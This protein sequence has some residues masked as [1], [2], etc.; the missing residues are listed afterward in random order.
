M[1]PALIVI[2]VQKAFFNEDAATRQSLD[3]AVEYI[4]A[5]ICL[6]R[7]LHLPVV[8]VQHRE[9]EDGLIPGSEG[10]EL[11]DAFEIHPEDIRIVKTYGNS[12]TRTSLEKDL[13]RLSVDTI[14]VTG[15]CAEYCVLSTCRGAED[16]DLMPILLRGSI[17]SGKPENIRF[18]ESINEVISL[19]A[20][21]QFIEHR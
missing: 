8:F 6:F 17:A 15:Y 9:D 7:S 3:S 18:V 16:V 21:S 13:K 10:F 5:A 20:L 1:K 2:D 12:F 11:S 4:N 19:G 14:I